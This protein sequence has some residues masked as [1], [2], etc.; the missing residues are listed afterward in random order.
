MGPP[1]AGMATA[2]G[3]P[4]QGAGRARGGRAGGARR[5]RGARRVAATSA[6]ASPPAPSSV[7]GSDGAHQAS[8]TR[9]YATELCIVEV[10]GPVGDAERLAESAALVRVLR[11]Q[12]DDVDELVNVT[13]QGTTTLDGR[14]AAVTT[15]V[16]VLDEALRDRALATARASVARYDAAMG[17][18]AAEA[19]D[20]GG[21]SD[22]GA[23]RSAMVAENMRLLD[24]AA[25]AHVS[26]IRVLVAEGPLEG[27]NGAALPRIED[28][29]WEHVEGAAFPLLLT[30][31]GPRTLSHLVAAAARYG[32]HVQS[33]TGAPATVW[34]AED[35]VRFRFR[36]RDEPAGA[37]HEMEWRPPE[38][39]ATRTVALTHEQFGDLVD[40]LDMLC[41]DHTV[42]PGIALVPEQLPVHSPSA[43]AAAAASVRAPL[44]GALCALAAGVAAADAA[45]GWR[46]LGTARRMVRQGAEVVADVLT[47]TSAGGLAALRGGEA[48]P[49]PP[50]PTPA[51][52]AASGEAA[53]AK[54]DD[55]KPE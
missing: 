50:L 40:A 28:A 8:V 18:N 14:L 22:D 19:S 44:V 20:D 34:V 2:R 29:T 48:A 52:P 39:D 27:V 7:D 23:W 16:R 11:Q 15:T 25:L 47:E 10:D 54:A 33:S 21:A 9:T 46:T 26:A 13:Q 17:V 5:R 30:S 38:A 35:T 4:A 41:T 32:A 43:A 37:F 49:S 55:V 45:S 6:P 53:G 1:S 24:S 3:R 12:T 36:G 31:R 42:M 51:P